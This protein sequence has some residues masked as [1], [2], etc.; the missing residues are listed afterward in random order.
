M[1]STGS[2]RLWQLPYT[3]LFVSRV[4]QDLAHGFASIAFVWLLVENGGNAV[5]TSILFFC[6]LV[7]QMLLSSLVSPLLAKGKLQNWMFYS[8]TI[9]AAAV[10]AIPLFFAFDAL[11]L[12][13]FFASALIQSAVASV[14]LPASVALL[15]LHVAHPD[16]CD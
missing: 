14:Y 1:Q 6:S 7:P 5:S 12:W 9:R 4:L 10:L 15:P 8:D 11:P 16:L 2:S 3:L 13:L